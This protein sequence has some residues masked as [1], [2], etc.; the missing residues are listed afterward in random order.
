LANFIPD[1]LDDLH[2][3]IDTSI[4]QQSKDQ[5]LLASFFAYSKLA[6]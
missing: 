3:A 5:D 2:E 4:T 6:L 1:D